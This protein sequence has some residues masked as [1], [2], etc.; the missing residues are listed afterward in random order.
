[1]GIR[2]LLMIEQG[3]PRDLAALV[4]PLVGSLQ[5][6]DDPWE[7]CR[8]CDPA[9]VVIGPVAVYLRDLQAAGRPETT[10][11]AYATALLRWLRFGWAVE[12]SA[13]AGRG[14][15][16]SSR[17]SSPTPSAPVCCSRPTSGATR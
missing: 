9:G 10:L 5:R 15:S 16:R 11:R 6:V 14:S 7:P 2:S 17:S 4:V 3:E 8:V 13:T 12:A 1:M